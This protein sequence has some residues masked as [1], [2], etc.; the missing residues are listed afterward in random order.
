MT[1]WTWFFALSALAAIPSLILLWW[2]DRQG[3]F[4]GMGKEAKA[5][6]A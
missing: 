2:L 4:D 5:K 3:H 6:T 1:G